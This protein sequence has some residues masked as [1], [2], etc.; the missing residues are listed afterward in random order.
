M[1]LSIPSQHTAHPLISRHL[2][3]ILYF[4]FNRSAHW[5]WDIVKKKI[6]IT[7]YSNIKAELTMKIKLKFSI[8][9]VL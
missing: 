7:D 3:H 2:S 1:A 9:T 4:S 5:G 8:I 6:I